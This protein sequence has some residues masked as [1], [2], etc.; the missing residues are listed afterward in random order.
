MKIQPIL[1]HRCPAPHFVDRGYPG[2]TSR[3]LRSL[4]AKVLE[5]AIHAA[6]GPSH[7]THYHHPSIH[8]NQPGQTPTPHPSSVS[9]VSPSKASRG[10]RISSSS[11]QETPL[12]RLINGGLAHSGAQVTEGT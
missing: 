12:P 1:F 4:P 2:R 6:H 7:Y 9:D 11:H 5:P 10:R 8:L 3:D